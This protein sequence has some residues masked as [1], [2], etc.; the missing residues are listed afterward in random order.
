[1]ARQSILPKNT[2]PGESTAELRAQP[3][4][5]SPNPSA[6]FPRQHLA[7]FLH[8]CN[9]ASSADICQRHNDVFIWDGNSR[10]VGILSYIVTAICPF[11]SLC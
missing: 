3:R 5:L 7:P 10:G 1:M 11:I 2:L 6:H 9:I 8:T 4:S